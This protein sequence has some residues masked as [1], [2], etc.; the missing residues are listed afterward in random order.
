MFKAF[1]AWEIVIAIAAL[2]IA[3]LMGAACVAG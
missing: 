2:A 3:A 1:D